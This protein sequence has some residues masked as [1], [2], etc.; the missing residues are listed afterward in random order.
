MHHQVLKISLQRW[1]LILWIAILQLLIACRSDHSDQVKLS[2][3]IL[4]LTAFCDVNIIEVGQREIETDYLP[5]VVACENGAAS[6]EALKAQAVAARSYLYYKLENYGEIAD[7]QSDQVY[8]CS[9]PPQTQHFEAVNETS[10]QVLLYQGVQVA[11]FYVA[12]AIPSRSDCIATE[13]DSDPHNTEQYVT[14]NEG[15]SG[16]ALQQTS[17]GWVNPN[18]FA[19]RGCQSQNGADCL[20]DQGWGYED[21]LRFYY[22]ADIEIQRAEGLCISMPPTN[23]D[24]PQAGEDSLEAG[25]ASEGG[26]ITPQG[27]DFPPSPVAGIEHAGIEHAGIEHAGIEHAGIEHAGIEHA[28]IEPMIQDPDMMIGGSTPPPRPIPTPMPA[29]ENPPNEDLMDFDTHEMQTSH[30]VDAG[31]TQQSMPTNSLWVLWILTVL[32]RSK[33]VFRVRRVVPKYMSL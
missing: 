20:S 18:N 6:F 16:D 19:N 14:Y 31:C 27:G 22:G 4:P 10:G 33:S 12:G 21:I 26:Q 1:I 24:P 7:G 29:P 25:L 23:P 9:R 28:G 5:H 17:L 2:K 8:S 32:Y 15:L 11:A 30:Q 3:Q 13:Q